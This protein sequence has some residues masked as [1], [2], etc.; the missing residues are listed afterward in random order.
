MLNKFITIALNL[1]MVVG[2]SCEARKEDRIAKVIGNVRSKSAEV[3]ERGKENN[4]IE[5]HSKFILQV[6]GK[7]GR[8]NATVAFTKEIFWRGPTVVFGHPAAYKITD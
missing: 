6:I 8:T 2:G 4:P 1:S 3:D 5:G 7:T